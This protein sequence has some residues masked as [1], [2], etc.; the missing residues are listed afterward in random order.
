M[1][2][3]N[4][5]NDVFLMNFEMLN[6]RE[7][8]TGNWKQELQ[9]NENRLNLSAKHTEWVRSISSYFWGDWGFLRAAAMV[10]AESRHLNI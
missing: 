5:D 7:D 9:L 3:S 10:S 6:N 4:D 8:G 1:T 2:V